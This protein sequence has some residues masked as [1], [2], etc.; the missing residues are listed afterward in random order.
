MGDIY[1]RSKADYKP[2]PPYIVPRLFP[3]M[4]RREDNYK[5][6]TLSYRTNTNLS[7]QSYRFPLS[8]VLSADRG[9]ALLSD[10]RSSR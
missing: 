8:S 10:P 5:K 6:Y 1:T 2:L 4:K 7:I 3:T 9:C